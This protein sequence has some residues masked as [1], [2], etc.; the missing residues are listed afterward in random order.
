[1]AKFAISSDIGTTFRT[2]NFKY[3]STFAAKSSPFTNLKLA[4]W[5]LH[6]NALLSAFKQFEMV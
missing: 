2:G 6:F 5:A 4:L 1:M 3:K